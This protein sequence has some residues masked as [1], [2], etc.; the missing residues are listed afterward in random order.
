ML[1]DQKPY[2][3]EK[4][5]IIIQLICKQLSSAEIA[6]E[7]QLSIRTVEDYRLDILKKQVQGI[8]LALLY[9]P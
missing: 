7:M 3:K 9:L 4:E 1:K 8:L 6:E 5:K 2:F